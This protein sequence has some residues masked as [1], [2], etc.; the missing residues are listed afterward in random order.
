MDSGIGGTIAEFHHVDDSVF[1]EFS[2]E[3]FRLTQSLMQAGIDIHMLSPMDRARVSAALWSD[4]ELF[5]EAGGL[6]AMFRESRG[7]LDAMY[8][9]DDEKEKLKS[10]DE[11]FDAASLS[12]DDLE[13]NWHKLTPAQKSALQRDWNVRSK[14]MAVNYFEQDD[15]SFANVGAAAIAASAAFLAMAN[16]PEMGKASPAY[17]L[18]RQHLIDQSMHERLVTSELSP[19]FDEIVK[20]FGI[21]MDSIKADEQNLIKEEG[22][23]VGKVEAERE[24]KQVAKPQDTQIE[25]SNSD[26]WVKK[27]EQQALNA[28]LKEELLSTN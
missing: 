25:T 5:A 12:L 17:Y 28:A 6:M 7:L 27:V 21:S 2:V 9:T 20:N 16:P 3:Y 22:F 10:F 19:N 13:D 14:N 18:S 8:L 15:L 24:P 4:N 23:W 1:E 11:H 26:E